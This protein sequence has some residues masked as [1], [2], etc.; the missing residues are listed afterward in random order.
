VRIILFF[1]VPIYDA[2]C[3]AHDEARFPR[4]REIKT[5]PALDIIPMGTDAEFA[6]LVWSIKKYGLYVPISIT[7]DG[8]VLDGRRRLL[9]CHAAGIEPRFETVDPKDPLAFVISKNVKRK[10]LSRSQVAL[11]DAL[12]ERQYP[13]CYDDPDCPI[14]VMPEARLI[15]QYDDLVQSV[16]NGLPLSEVH[17]RALER[18]RQRALAIEQAGQLDHLRAQAPFLALRV[19]EGT[20]TLDQALAQAEEDAAAPL[21]R[22]HAGA[23]RALGRRMIADAIEIGRRLVECRRMIRHGN[24]IDWLDRELGVT[25]RCA[26]DFIRVY[27]LTLARSENFPDFNLPV[28]GLYL[29]A[30]PGT[31]ESVRDDVFRRAAA[32]EV[33]SLADIKHEMGIE[34]PAPDLDADLR[35]IA[36]RLADERPDNALVQQLQALVA[37]IA[38]DPTRADEKR[39]AGKPTNNRQALISNKEEEHEQIQMGP[40]RRCPPLRGRH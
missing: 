20:L 27:E 21:L 37:K 17:R 28:S 6:R 7:G 4:L 40:S 39:V 23:I 5:H 33:L 31:P 24:W 14:R 32:G 36:E 12:F 25:D 16:W 34:R 10:H 2:A 15:A 19:D 13:G 11:S 35:R 22:E 26:L 8:L 3:R 30:R 9:A 18:E 38:A 1:T 29:L